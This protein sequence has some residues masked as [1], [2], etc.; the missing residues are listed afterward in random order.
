M[1]RSSGSYTTV[2]G[3]GTLTKSANTCWFLHPPE[4]R[5]PFAWMVYMES[6][7]TCCRRKLSCQPLG[8]DTGALGKEG[9]GVPLQLLS[10]L[11]RE[12][13]RSKLTVT[14]PLVSSADMSSSAESKFTEVFK[15]VSFG[16]GR[17]GHFLIW[18]LTRQTIELKLPT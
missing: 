6:A 7:W 16:T 8:P 2:V 18:S 13:Q 17:G 4:P 11:R 3:E 5:P 12:T 1:L 14:H 10:E 15:P 9:I